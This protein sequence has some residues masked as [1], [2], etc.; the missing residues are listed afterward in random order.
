MNRREF[1]ALSAAAAVAAPAGRVK[2]G[3]QTR[4]YYV[5]VKDRAKLLATLDAISAAGFVG[6]ETNQLC[7]QDDFASPAPMKDELSRRKLELFGLHAGARL[8]DSTGLEKARLDVTRVANGVRALGGSYVVVSPAAVRD[9]SGAELQAAYHR[10][11]EALTE[12]GRICNGAGVKLAIHNHLEETRR[13]WAEFRVLAE[14][15]R[16]SEVAMVVDVGPS[17]LTGEDPASFLSE[18][19][20]RVAG[21]HF[22]D[23]RDGRQ[24][25]LGA[26]LVNL[27]GVA[28]ALNKRRWK[29]WA[30]VE[31][32]G[33]GIPGLT[34]DQAARH[35]LAHIRDEMKLGA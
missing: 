14:K 5:P 11:A 12:L 32:E 7:M 30:I 27:R 33:G 6:F 21:L 19:H 22:R 13:G 9:L 29:G 15:T 26:G 4:S 3:C 10:K 23:Y 17:G 2:I 18:Y 24:V 31:L 8:L 34:A 20:L 1:V 35:A 16:Q 28:E 25:K